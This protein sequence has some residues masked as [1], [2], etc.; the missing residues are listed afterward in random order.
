VPFT[1][2]IQQPTRTTGRLTGAKG[3]RLRR[4]DAE[5]LVLMS[6]GRA[7]QDGE[8]IDLTARL[9]AGL[10]NERGGQAVIRRALPTALPWTRF[11]PT[12]AVDELITEFVG[13]IGAAASV[14]NMAPVTQLLAEWRHTAEIYADPELHTALTRAHE[15]D[16]GAVPAPGAVA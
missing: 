8:V 13:M 11:L 7:Q 5:D 15:G 12:E 2:L 16:Y 4:R 3:L 6:A 9:L 1:E 10:I 14:N